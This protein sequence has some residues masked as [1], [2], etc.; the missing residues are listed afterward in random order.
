MTKTTE[1]H[2]PPTG[3]LW[4]LAHVAAY[5]GCADATPLTRMAGFPPP[6]T[7][8]GVRGPRWCPDQVIA[9]FASLAGG[10]VVVED[11]SAGRPALRPI[12]ADEMR[13]R[14]R[15]A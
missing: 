10:A 12:A 15:S 14:V 8:P 1:R 4:G 6:M 13:N 11:A 7:L 5:V 3:L 2:A 9:Y